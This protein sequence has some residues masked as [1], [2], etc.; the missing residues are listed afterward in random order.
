MNFESLIAELV[1]KVDEHEKPCNESRRS[2]ALSKAK[3]APP[4][5]L[6]VRNVSAEE[7]EAARESGLKQN[8]SLDLD[9]KDLSVSLRTEQTVALEVCTLR[10]QI[11]TLAEH[12]A[13]A[14]H[15]LDEAHR[16][17]GFLEAQLLIQE[18]QIRQF[19]QER[20]ERPKKT[21]SAKSRR[22]R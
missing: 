14:N 6:K 12:L 16:K 5:Q 7:T 8:V 21:R 9:Y 18:E 4:E 15:K 11:A 1:E 2:M 13:H 22:A 10:A 20:C 19:R 3:K 17:V